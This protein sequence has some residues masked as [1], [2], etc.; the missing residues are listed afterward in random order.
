MQIIAIDYN[1]SSCSLQLKGSDIISKECLS[2]I[3][4]NDAS[5]MTN[6]E[7]KG[8]MCFL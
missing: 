3:S 8:S 5:N 6:M 2:A 4:S 7:Y 1:Y